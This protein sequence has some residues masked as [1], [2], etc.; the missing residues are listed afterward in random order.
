M[1]IREKYSQLLHKE[2]E[3]LPIFQL[4]ICEG[5]FFLYFNQ[6]NISQQTEFLSR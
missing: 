4:R 1:F 6:N 5:I 2:I 3:I